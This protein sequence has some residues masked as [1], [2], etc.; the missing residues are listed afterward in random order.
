MIKSIDRINWKPENIIIVQLVFVLFER[1]FVQVCGFPGSIIYLLDVLNIMLFMYSWKRKTW[2]QYSGLVTAYMGIIGLSLITGTIYYKEWG[3]NL[4]SAI[5]EIRNT[6]RFLIFLISCI[7]FLNEE[8]CRKI[9]KRL[10]GFFFINTVAILYQYVTFY[11]P[12]V[13]MRGD[14]L[15]GL[16][17]TQ[18]GGNTFVNVILIVVVTYM[19][20]QWSKGQLS[21][22][23]FFAA[24]GLSLLIAGLIELKA[25]FVEFVALYGWY[26]IKKKKSKK[27]VLFNIVIIGLFVCV[28]GLALQ[29]MFREYP[30][31]RETMSISGMIKSLGGDGYT[32]NGD[33]NRFTG[34]FT[35]ASRFF[36][37][38]IAKILLGIGAGNC[39]ASSVLGSTAKFYTQYMD[40]HYNWFS[41]T[42]LF[43]QGGAI[44]LLLYLFTFIYL[45]FKKK[46]NKQFALNSQII[47]VLAVFLV[48]YGEALRTDAG[49]FIYFAIASGFVS[50]NKI[51]GNVGSKKYE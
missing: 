29:I 21:S 40:S 42:Y 39:S 18:T 4:F 9:Y 19:L 32:G 24:V 46:Q 45:F 27:E 14:M 16:F 30:W 28:S 25:F 1:F 2:G 38:D 12:G 43:V 13:W 10:I 22:K 33:L 11:P 35:I 41:A 49:Y 51:K 15:N 48:F 31:F 50:S 5:I 8:K 36:E 7:T 3:G 44:G 6:V 26:L 17:G 20:T 47:C 34:V 37:G 23:I